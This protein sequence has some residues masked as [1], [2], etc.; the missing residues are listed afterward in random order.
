MMSFGTHW[1]GKDQQLVPFRPEHLLRAELKDDEL[2]YM[3]MMPEWYE[4]IIDTAFADLSWSFCRLGQVACMFGI[5]PL[6]PGVGEVWMIPT[7]HTSRSAIALIKGGIHILDYIQE[8]YGVR[9]LQITVRS[10]NRTA[11]KYAEKMYFKIEGLMEL[12]GP[13]GEDYYMMA[14]IRNGSS[15]DCPDRSVSRSCGIR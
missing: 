13:E 10:S 9:R 6:W 11:Y 2:K 8:E 5:R 15:T 14:R 1:H 4:Y 7:V 12:F 3:E